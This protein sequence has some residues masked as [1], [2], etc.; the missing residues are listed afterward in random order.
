MFSCFYSV[1]LQLHLT[2]F[3]TDLQHEISANRRR[4]YNHEIS[5]KVFDYFDFCGL[6]AYL[7]FVHLSDFHGLYGSP[8]FLVL[9]NLLMS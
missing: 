2:P 9:V 1:Y 3:Q 7:P 6:A 8:R 4:I 5:L